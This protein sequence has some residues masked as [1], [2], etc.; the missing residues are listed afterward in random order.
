LDLSYRDIRRPPISLWE[1]RL[2]IRRL[3]EEGRAHVDENAIFQSIEAMRKIAL[4]AIRTS[5]AARRQHERRMRLIRGG[6]DPEADVTP[7][8]VAE[9]VPEPGN[10]RKPWEDMLPV[11]EW[12]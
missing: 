12:E 6:L 1:H 5:K 9:P 2:A 7:S 11:E 3:R 10:R 8:P 4:D